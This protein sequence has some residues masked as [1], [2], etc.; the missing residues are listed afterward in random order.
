MYKNRGQ[1]QNKLTFKR[2]ESSKAL[3][4]NKNQSIIKWGRKSD[5]SG[6]SD[7][8]TNTK[9]LTAKNGNPARLTFPMGVL[10]ILE[11]TNKQTPTGGVVRPMI[12][13]RTAITVK[14][15]GST[16]TSIATFNRMGNKIK[17]AAIVSIKVPTKISSRLISKSTAYLLV[18][19][20][21]LMMR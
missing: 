4:S 12:K 16:S 5:S 14:C 21:I 1:P 19:N 18:V 20:N 7:T 8:N 13:F 17:R 2:L 9:R 6:N 15:M 11:A 10:P 3:Q